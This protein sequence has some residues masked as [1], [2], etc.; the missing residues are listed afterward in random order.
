MVMERL[1]DC[2]CGCVVTSPHRCARL[3]TD[4]QTRDVNVAGLSVG[5]GVIAPVVVAALVSRN[6]AAAVIN[7]ANEHA[8]CSAVAD[9]AGMLH[10]Q[11]LDVYHHEAR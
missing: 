9:I 6:D 3:G 4:D 1:R 7:A 11:K 2:H 10:F 8:T 5:V